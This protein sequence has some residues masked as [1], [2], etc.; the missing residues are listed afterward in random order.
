MTAPVRFVGRQTELSGL[1]AALADAIAGQGGLA[2][3]AGEPGIGKTRFAEELATE[4][5]R[6]GAVVFWGRCY[7]DEGAPAFWPWREA[8]R[9]HM[10]GRDPAALRADLGN[11]AVDVAQIVPELGTLLPDLPAPLP[12]SQG[13]IASPTVDGP[14]ARFRQFDA[15]TAFLTGAATYQPLVIILDDLHWADVPSLLLLEFVVQQAAGARLLLVATYRDVEV[16]PSH[17]L[18]RTLGQLARAPCA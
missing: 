17:P 2:L 6:C 18:A 8:I 3:V 5:Q 12:A 11:G 9:A 15:V 13:M 10:R 1:T 4:A 14:Q 7:E 16:T